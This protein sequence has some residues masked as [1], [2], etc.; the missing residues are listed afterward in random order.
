MEQ[1]EK[2]DAVPVGLLG[3]LLIAVKDYNGPG[4]VVTTY[5]SPI[6]ANNIAKTPDATIIYQ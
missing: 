4:G 6:Y 3:G 5:A 2:L 1:A